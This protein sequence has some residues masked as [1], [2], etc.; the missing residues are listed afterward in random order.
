MSKKLIIGGVG[1]IIIVILISIIIYFKGGNKPKHVKCIPGKCSDE[2]PCGPE[3]TCE[4]NGTCCHDECVP[5]KCGKICG[6]K[7]IYCPCKPGETC[8]TGN[9]KCEV[10]CGDKVCGDNGYNMSCGKC[11]DGKHCEDGKCV[12]EPDCDGKQCGPDGCGGLCGKCPDG[13]HCNGDNHC[14]C[15]PDCDD[16]VCGDDGCGGSCGGCGDETCNT[17]GHCECDKN[18]CDTNECGSDGCGG[19][20]GKC[21]DGTHCKKGQ[22]VCTPDCSSKKC[23]ISDGCGGVC[24]CP[25]GKECRG[26]GECCDIGSCDPS[27]KCFCPTGQ[28]C[29]NGKCCTTKQQTCNNFCGDR[30]CGLPKCGCENNVN[31]TDCYKNKCC[32]FGDTCTNYSDGRKDGCDRVCDEKICTDEG[33]IHVL[34]KCYAKHEPIDFCSMSTDQMT[35]TIAGG[36]GSVMGPPTCT[37]CKDTM[38]S[39]GGCDSCTITNPTFSN[40]SVIPTGG[41]LT[42]TGCCVTP[43]GHG[44]E[45]AVCDNSSQSITLTPDIIGIKLDTSG[46]LVPQTSTIGL[47]PPACITDDDCERLKLHGKKCKSMSGEP[48]TM[49][50]CQ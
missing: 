19:S 18:L 24:G 44:H 43:S 15:K 14:V 49:K 38:F 3:Q 25:D 48:H 16:V 13:K 32:T 50:V 4:S 11:P 35:S 28:V 39:G 1:I 26:N 30:G 20:C 12:C 36:F 29:N 33:R 22:C 31:G 6:D 21:K 23:G 37:T 34:G 7:G 42:C 2:C 17:T 46:K 9:G 40:G 41:I 45:C 5:G 10:S 8:N 27:K 47:L